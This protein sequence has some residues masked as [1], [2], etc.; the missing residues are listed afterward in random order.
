MPATKLRGGWLPGGPLLSRRLRAPS[1]FANGCV[2]CHLGRVKVH[3][4]LEVMCDRSLALSFVGLYT[5]WSQ[6]RCSGRCDAHCR[7]GLSSVRECQSP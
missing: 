3:L 1:E 7:V 4:V 2:R 5:A 6:R